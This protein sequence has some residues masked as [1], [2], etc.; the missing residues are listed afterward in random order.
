[1]KAKNI[2]LTIDE[3]RL[4]SELTFDHS[5]LQFKAIVKKEVTLIL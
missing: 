4:F 5:E 1:M 3:N 2:K